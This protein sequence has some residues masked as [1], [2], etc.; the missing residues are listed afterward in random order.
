MRL[1]GRHPLLNRHFQQSLASDG[2][3][4][5]DARRLVFAGPLDLAG[6]VAL[7]HS[8]RSAGSGVTLLAAD[9]ED[10][11]AYLQRMDVIRRMP[12]GAV[13]N[14]TLPAEKRSLLPHALLEVSPL[15]SGTADDVGTRLGRLAAHHFADAVAAKIFAAVGELIDNTVDHGA[16]QEGAFVAA[17]VYTGTTSGRRG[18]EVAICDTGIGVLAHLRRNPAHSDLPDASRALERALHAGVTGTADRR[19]NGL[20]DL[21]LHLEFG[22]LARF[23]LRSGDGLTTVTVNGARRVTRSHSTTTQVAGTWAWLRIRIP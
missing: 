22:G 10:V 7:A 16:S 13:I 3:L 17:Q 6:M 12:P 1:S 2:E 4:V 14:G 21:L 20:S 8:A 18:L 23:H 5:I 11:A 15:S 9:N 19:G